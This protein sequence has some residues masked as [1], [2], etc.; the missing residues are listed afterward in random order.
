MADLPLRFIPI[1]VILGDQEGME[2]LALPSAF[3]S[4]GSDNLSIDKFASVQSILGY[5]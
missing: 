4:G 3:S 1:G 2:S 5:A